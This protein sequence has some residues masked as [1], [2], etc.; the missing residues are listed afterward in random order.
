MRLGRP[1]LCPLCAE[2]VFLGLGQSKHFV[3]NF[4]AK[5]FVAKCWNGGTSERHIADELRNT[6]DA[7]IAC[8]FFGLV[9]FA[10]AGGADL[11]SCACR[12]GSGSAGLSTAVHSFWFFTALRL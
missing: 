4:A 11:R 6:S 5:I 1:M 2:L 12:I 7:S 3:A 9:A 8:L 10:A